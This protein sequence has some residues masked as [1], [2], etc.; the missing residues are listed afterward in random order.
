MTTKAITPPEGRLMQCKH[1]SHTWWSHLIPP[2]MP[3]QCPSCRTWK[4]QAPSE[5]LTEHERNR[6]KTIVR[7]RERGTR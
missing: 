3:G 7:A 4:W 6:I 1:C 2:T 5:A